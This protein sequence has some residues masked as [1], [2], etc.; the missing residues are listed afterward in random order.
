LDTI[1][2]MAKD[3]FPSADPEE[4][5]ELQRLLAIAEDMAAYE[6]RQDEIKAATAALEAHRAEFEAL[7]SDFPTALD[8]AQRLFSE[9]EFASFRYTVADIHQAFENAGYPRLYR[10]QPGEEDMEIVVAAMLSLVGEEDRTHLSRR[11]LLFLPEYVATGRYMDAWMIQ[12]SAFQMIDSPESSNPFL[13]SMF[14]LAYDEWEQQ[15]QSQRGDFLAELG[16]TPAQLEQMTEEEIEAWFDAQMADPERRA[17]AEEYYQQYSIVR[18]QTESDFYEMERE[19]VTL[20]DRDD[21][22]HLY[23]SREEVEPWVLEFMK[24]QAPIIQEIRAAA[25]GGRRPDLATIEKTQLVINKVV[26]EMTES[27]FTAERKRQLAE[28]LVAYQNQ[29]RSSG[30]REAAQLAYVVSTTVQYNESPSANLF[31]VNICFRSLRETMQ[32]IAEEDRKQ[33]NDGA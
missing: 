9:D 25:A 18:D 5:E 3:G 19:S 20:L 15:L 14:F 1:R 10:E 2:Q 21:A 26:D 12:L 4:R 29:L 22:R 30:D 23:L 11:L 27:I 16:I 7:M 24:R 28:D 8:Y 17:Q 33:K 32:K 31:L 6:A 13:T